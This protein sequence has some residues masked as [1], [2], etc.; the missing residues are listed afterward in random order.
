M[1][2]NI[3]TVK[4]L[5]KTGFHIEDIHFSHRYDEDSYDHGKLDNLENRAEATIGKAVYWTGFLRTGYDYWWIEFKRCGK[6]YTCKAN[7]YCYLTAS[8]AKDGGPVVL[9][10]H[11][12][13]MIV[14][15]PKSSSCSVSLYESAQLLQMITESHEK[16]GLSDAGEEQDENKKACMID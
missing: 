3:A 11:E 1:G 7:F 12:D 4:V 15:P 16:S 14:V 2:K 5:N 8:D 13:K 6:I 10:L 9:E